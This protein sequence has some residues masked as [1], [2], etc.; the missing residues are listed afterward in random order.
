MQAV[1]F[2]PELQERLDRF[3]ALGGVVDYC[4]FSLNGAEISEALHKEAA[5]GFMEYIARAKN[6]A[7]R[8]DSDAAVGRPIGR[9]EFMGPYYHWKRRRL[10]VRGTGQYVNRYFLAGAPETKENVVRLP[11]N[12][13]EYVTQGYAQA[14]SE[15]SYGMRAPAEEVNRLFLE[16]NQQLFSGFPAE[17]EIRRWSTDWAGYFDAGHEWWGSFLWTLYNPLAGWIVAVGAST[18]D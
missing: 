2:D 12:N 11:P 8:I 14:F 18:T 13:S 7:F 5:V 6:W 3:H 16:I 4:A 10:I 1:V 9:E 17:L 15:P